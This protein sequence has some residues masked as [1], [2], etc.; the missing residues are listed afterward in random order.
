MGIALDTV[1]GKVYWSDFA[2]GKVQRR[3]IDGS[4][5]V[6]D[7]VT[8]EPG[9]V[10]R[11]AVDP[12]NNALY[13]T[14]WTAGRIIK[15]DLNGQNRQQLV[16]GLI[17]PDGLRLKDNQLYFTEEGTERVKRIDLETS[18]IEVICA[19]STGPTGIAIDTASNRVFYNNRNMY[20]TEEGSWR[21]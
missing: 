3:N 15:A 8:G 13:W 17:N 10:G 16:T 14:Q 2:G 5:P 7:L 9:W 19:T 18:R 4:G 1:N 12:A 11:I 6:E 20:W 21:I